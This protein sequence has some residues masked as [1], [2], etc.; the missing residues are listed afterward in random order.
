[1]TH[2]TLQELTAALRDSW[3][4]E[5]AYDSSDWSQGN[6]ARGQCVVSTLIVQDYLGGELQK[7]KVSGEVT[8]THYAN[9]IDGLLVDVSFSQYD[10][11]QVTLTPVE[12][13]LRGFKT[14]RDKL[15]SDESTKRRYELLKERV[16][17]R[18]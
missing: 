6:P 7:Y 10:S 11:Y 18:L 14:L 15:L 3:S 9:R 2:V 1:M 4:A 16:K 5:T 8:E 13:N 17:E 12:G